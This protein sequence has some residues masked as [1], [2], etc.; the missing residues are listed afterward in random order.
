MQEDASGP[1]KFVASTCIIYDD[2]NTTQD[3]TAKYGLEL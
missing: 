3:L 1:M 2:I